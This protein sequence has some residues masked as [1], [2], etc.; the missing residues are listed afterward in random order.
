MHDAPLATTGPATRHRQAPSA[1]LDTHGSACCRSLQDAGGAAPMVVPSSEVREGGG[2]AGSSDG[3]G[4]KKRCGAHPFRRGMNPRA[5]PCG[6]LGRASCRNHARSQVSYRRA[7]LMALAGSPCCLTLGSST[8]RPDRPALSPNLGEACRD[9]RQ[10]AAPNERPECPY[11]RGR[12]RPACEPQT[13]SSSFPLRA[14]D[15]A[16]RLFWWGTPPTIL[17]RLSLDFW[18]CL[19]RET[20][21][22]KYHNF[23]RY[24]RTN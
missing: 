1:M 13:A 20:K 19:A 24:S 22:S 12:F 5:L 23:R 15:P 3:F 7:G 14:A 9:P 17:P 8:V 21:G 2:K 10:G 6:S 18:I 4:G 16:A 11:H